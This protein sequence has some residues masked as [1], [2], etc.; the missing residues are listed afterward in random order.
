MHSITA[1]GVD[2][3]IRLISSRGDSGT[4]CTDFGCLLRLSSHPRAGDL[5]P[6]LA[7]CTHFL[8]VCGRRPAMPAWSEMLGDRP[9][10]GEK[11]LC[12]AWGLEPLHAPFPLPRRLV[13]VLSAVIEIAVLAVLHTRKD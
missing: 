11:P 8:P 13:R 2:N 3:L 12:L 7:S 1:Q 6:H 9:I 5:F 10:R 4:E